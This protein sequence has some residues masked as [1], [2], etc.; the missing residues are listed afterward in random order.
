[1]GMKKMWLAVKRRRNGYERNSLRKEVKKISK[2]EWSKMTKVRI[3]AVIR[4]KG[5]NGME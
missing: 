4:Q 2:A 1:M 5:D 3:M